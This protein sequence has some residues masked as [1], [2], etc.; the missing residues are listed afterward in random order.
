METWMLHIYIITSCYIK[1]WVPSSINFSIILPNAC[2]GK[3]A[4]AIKDLVSL[5]A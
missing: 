1:L 5:N 3:V 2:V 4:T